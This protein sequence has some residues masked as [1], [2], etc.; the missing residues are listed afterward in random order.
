MNIS[1]IDRKTGALCTEKVYGENA[2][3]LLYGD[4]FWQR[5]FS[6]LFL[7]LLAKLPFSSQLYGYFQKTRYSARKVA[8]FIKSYQIDT[9]EFVEE[10]FASFND[11]FIRKLKP[12][13]RPI[14]PNGNCLVTPAD[15]RYLVYSKIGAFSI[16]GK[17]FSLSS[18]LQD[19]SLAKRYED[20]S[21]AL[22]RLCPIDYHRFHFPCDGTADSPRLIN[23][24]LYSVNP[25]AL[26]KRLAILFENKRVLTEIQT[27]HFG[28]IIYA[29]IGATSVGSI[30]QTFVN[31]QVK[32]GEEKGYFEFGGSCLLLLFEKDKVSFAPDLLANTE[33]GLETRSNF[34]DLL[35][36]KK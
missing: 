26:K 28:K 5:L 8:P 30:Q 19:E 24:P 9:S 12:E 34:G 15:G 10:R 6:F 31:S 4:R 7:P 25:I 14:H 22:I 11:F 32:K 1:F 16:K 36:S 35:A 33:K 27:S 13:R 29:E 2:L 23:G 18:F 21:M 20:G 17:T 3:A